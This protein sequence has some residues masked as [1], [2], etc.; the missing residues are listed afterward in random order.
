MK[1]P[2]LKYQS[3]V[4]LIMFVLMLMGVGGILFVG[5]SQGLLEAVEVKKFKHNTRVLKEAKQTLLQYAYNYPQ[6]NSEGP[7]RLPC[8]APDDTGFTGGLTLALCQSVGRLPWAESEMNFYDARD[9]DGVQ[10]WYA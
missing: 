7:G 4:A 1:S 6:F 9:A 10:L 5:Y 8:P 3:G 2:N